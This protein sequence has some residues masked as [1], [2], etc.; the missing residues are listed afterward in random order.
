VNE[1][2]EPPDG[3][4]VVDWVVEH[5]QGPADVLHALDWPDPVRRTVWVLDV[6]AP[7]LVLGSTQAVDAIDLDS[8]SRAGFELTRRRSG[9]GAV[10]LEPGRSV[11]IDAFIPRHDPCWND[12]VGRSFAWL[13]QA[14]AAALDEL[15]MRGAVVHAGGLQCGRYGRRVCFAGIGPGEVSIDGVK[16]VGLSQRRTR[17]GARFQC[18]VYRMYD[19]APLIA[20]AD[21][22]PADLPP[23][24][25]VDR[26][27]SAIESAL[28][29]HLP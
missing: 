10:L 21:V 16:V 25:V 26:P 19:P 3:E 23:V 13:G 22:V 6:A 28:L 11:W 4:R 1:R 14:W 8:L 9:G 27:A 15:G 18:V 29:R 12:D 17:A 7:A 24:L 20:L 5:E 2:P